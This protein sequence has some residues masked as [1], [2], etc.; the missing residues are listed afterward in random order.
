MKTEVLVALQVFTSPDW[1]RASQ[2][3]GWTLTGGLFSPSGQ[4]QKRPNLAPP[5]SSRMKRG[6]Q[7][8]LANI[9]RVTLL[10]LLRRLV[11]ACCC[12]NRVTSI[13]EGMTLNGAN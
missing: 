4:S 3:R 1:T 11:A 13:E 5:A 6:E 10:A 12:V 9:S 8:L 7:K 2:S